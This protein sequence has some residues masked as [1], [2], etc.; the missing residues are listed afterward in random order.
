M[1]HYCLH[2]DIVFVYIYV[3]ACVGECE[4][5]WQYCS[6]FQ[7]IITLNV[8]WEDSHVLHNVISVMFPVYFKELLHDI[9][10]PC[11]IIGN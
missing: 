5:N 6:C 4:L 9:T 7:Q 11:I 8:T 10:I 2:V 3:C 1:L